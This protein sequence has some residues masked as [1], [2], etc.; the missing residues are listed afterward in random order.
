MQ[1]AETMFSSSSVYLQPAFVLEIERKRCQQ[2]KTSQKALLLLKIEADLPNVMTDLKKI[3]GVNEV[4]PTKGL[5][6]VVVLVEAPSF[7]KLRKKVLE[8]VR[9]TANVKNTLT[10]TLL[11]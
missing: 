3:E 9:Q 1:Q 10:L 6:D 5:Y 11:N 4:Y 2:P 8:N 7:E